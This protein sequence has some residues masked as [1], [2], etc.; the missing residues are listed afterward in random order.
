MR[1]LSEHDS[2]ARIARRKSISLEA[3]THHEV[4]HDGFTTNRGCR[5]PAKNWKEG[6]KPSRKSVARKGLGSYTAPVRGRGHTQ[7]HTALFRTS[8]SS[9]GSQVARRLPGRHSSAAASP[10]RCRTGLFSGR[11]GSG[12]PPPGVLRWSSCPQARKD[13][14]P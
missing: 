7:P 3:G 5:A 6:P 10:L 11:R 9:V 2:R 13:T 12:R 1:A 14:S 4:L 8:G